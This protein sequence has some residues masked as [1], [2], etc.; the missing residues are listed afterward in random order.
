MKVFNIENHGSMTMIVSADG[1][2]YKAM[3]TETLTD[4]KLN[5]AIKSVTRF[6]NEVTVND[7]R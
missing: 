1:M 6:Y 4:S 7:L 2:V 5:R 3:D